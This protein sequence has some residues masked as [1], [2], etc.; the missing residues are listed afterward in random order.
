MSSAVLKGLILG[1]SFVKRLQSD[2]KTTFDAHADSNFHLEGTATVHLLG[3]GSQ[4]VEKLWRYD[5]HVL[6]CLAPDVVILEVTTKDL[7]DVGLEVVGLSIEELVSSLLDAF[8]ISVVGVCHVIPCSVYFTD[9][10]DFSQFAE[11][12]NNYVCIMLEPFPK[13]F[14]WT[15][16]DFSSPHKDL[17]LEDGIHLYGSISYIRATAAA[18]FGSSSAHRL[19]PPPAFMSCMFCN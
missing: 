3:V 4:T 7:L 14:C 15:H 19:P 16:R 13:V 5:L 11:V 8:S 18:Y 2:L 1:H 17:Y 6:R 12:L 9:W 10:E